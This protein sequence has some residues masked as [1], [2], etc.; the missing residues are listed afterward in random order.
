MTD[1]LD[2]IHPDE[3]FGAHGIPHPPP[4]RTLAAP[5]AGN[6]AAGTVIHHWDQ[7]PGRVTPAPA[8]RLRLRGG[9]A[10][11]T[12]WRVRWFLDRVEG[13]TRSQA[14]RALYDVLL[15]A[16]GWTRAG[17]HLARTARFAEAELLVRVIPASTTRCGTGAAACF[18]WG[19]ESHNKPVVELGVEYLG[20]PEFAN[21]INHELGHALYAMH[22]M[23]ARP[24]VSGHSGFE[25]VMGEWAS[26][27]KSGYYP[28]ENEVLWAKEWLQGK[29]Q[30]VHQ[31]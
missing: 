16:K 14:M 15:H 19:F 5:G 4:G 26:S 7:G 12:R 22:D 13:C 23:Y 28:N 20:T 11:T 1:L 3:P 24:G 18:S 30:Y 29:A 9:G 31:H 8:R 25:G 17:V 21:L 10:V 6:V 2:P 27:A